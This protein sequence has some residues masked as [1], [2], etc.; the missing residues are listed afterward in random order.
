MNYKNKINFLAVTILFLVLGAG[1]YESKPVDPKVIETVSNTP[2][3]AQD[4]D[5]KTG[6][7]N[8]FWPTKS[9]TTTQ[10]FSEAHPALDIAGKL[11]DPIYAAAN[12]VVERA[13]CTDAEKGCYIILDHG[14]GVKTM[15]GHNAKLNVAV[16]DKIK[17]EQKIALMGATGKLM[18]K[19][20]GVLHFEVSINGTSVD[21]MKLK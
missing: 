20:D 19:P 15:Y 11:N 4:Y 1:C 7:F 10:Y 5:S 21:P 17:K 14:S 2:A 6:K 16:G 8:Y 18:G 12:G 3:I 13:D 9:E